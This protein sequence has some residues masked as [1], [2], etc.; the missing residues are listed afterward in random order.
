MKVSL[1]LTTYNCLENLK[2]TL[3]AINNQSYE[4]IEVVVKDGG[5]TDGTINYIREMASSFKYP[6]VWKSEKDTGIYD[7]LNKGIEMSSGDIIA[8]CNDL[9]TSNTVV[10]Q[11]VD[12][13]IK[14]NVDGV[15]SD[16][17]Y[18]DG[19]R[20]VR[21]WKM[22]EGKISNGW[23]PG[24][25][26]L[27]LKREIYEKYG[28]YDTRYR[29]AADYEFIVRI[30]KD[31]EVKLA[32]IPEVLISMYYN[33]TSNSSVKAYWNSIKESYRA[34]KQN[35]VRFPSLLIIKRTLKVFFQFMKASKAN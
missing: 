16:L 7:A 24:H 15:H 5:S 20:V 2:L 32:Y 29:I 31:D 18:K 25:P 1:I 21:Y 17:V 8:I 35:H 3:D 13:I 33:G 22:G 34:L 9:L 10:E 4:D 26:T 23:M 27:Y 28:L 11:F 6:I 12:A 30:L 14:N 19:D